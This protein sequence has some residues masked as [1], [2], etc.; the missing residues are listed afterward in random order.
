M[1]TITPPYLTIGIPVYNEIKHLNSTLLSIL[2]EVDESTYDIEI[3]VADNGSDDGTTEY[4]D[5]FVEDEISRARFNV[6]LIKQGKNRGFNFNCDTIIR[7]SNG[8]YLWVLGAQETLLPGAL[9]EIFKCLNK[10][11]RQIVINAQVWDEASD[12]LANPNIYGNRPDSVYEDAES[13]YRDLGGPCRSLSLNI[14]RT[15]LM[16]KSLELEIS[17]HY[18][19]MYERHAFA[20][21]INA[22]QGKYCF[23]NMSAVRILIE[24]SGWQLSGND[25]FGAKVVSK[26]FPGFHADLEM[27]EIGLRMLKY[28]KGIGTSIGVW[29]DKFG[30]VRTFSTA[31]SY[32]L[33]I[34][35]SLF[36]RCIRIYKRSVWFWILGA[37]ILL[38]PRNFFSP[39]KLEMARDFTHVVRRILN[40]P[41]K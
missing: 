13:F 41:S 36:L 22:D 39:R 6:K 38:T 25:D 27:A 18:W 24:E 16:K 20:S 19:G 12:S 21:V 40:K 8:R 32:G 11:P 15:D 3:I 4:L 17:S 26:A 29:R 35:P 37:P 9:N 14:V 33:K 30:L 23:L 7:A 2:R 28:G 10:E 31:K 1:T 34:T 5:D